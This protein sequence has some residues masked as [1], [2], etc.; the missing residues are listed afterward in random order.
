MDKRLTA[1]NPGNLTPQDANDIK[2]T[3][4]A[5]KDATLGRVK[6]SDMYMYKADHPI[7][8]VRRLGFSPVARH[9]ELL[10]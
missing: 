1:Q 8:Q 3:A 5:V 4:A 7:W 9:C 10:T 6:Q 2:Y